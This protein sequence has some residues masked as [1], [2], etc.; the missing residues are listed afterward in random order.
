MWHIKLFH[1]VAQIDIHLA[2]GYEISQVAIL[3]PKSSKNGHKSSPN[4]EIDI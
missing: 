4:F 3:K 2:I 1:L